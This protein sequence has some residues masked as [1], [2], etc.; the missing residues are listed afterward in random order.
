MPNVTFKIALDSAQTFAPGTQ[1]PTQL[2]VKLSKAGEQIGEQWAVIGGQNPVPVAFEVAES[3]WVRLE[4]TAYSP[5]GLVGSVFAKD[6]N[7]QLV[8]LGLPSGV[9]V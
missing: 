1:A 7:V 8:T 3:G 9:S 2:N 5:A 4:I 6:E